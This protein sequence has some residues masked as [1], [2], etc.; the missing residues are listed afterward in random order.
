[1]ADDLEQRIEEALQLLNSTTIP[2]CSCKADGSH[3]WICEPCFIHGVICDMKREREALKEQR[4]DEEWTSQNQRC[5]DMLLERV[6][7][8]RREREDLKKQRDVAIRHLAQWCAAISTCG[9]DWD[10][11]DQ[12]YKDARFN[13]HALPEIRTL[14]NQA[15]ETATKDNTTIMEGN[16]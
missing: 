7:D 8:M 12:Y 5:Y 9:G 15:M 6:C 14:L 11:W 16:A 1:M 4:K 3:I 2:T 10:E 13:E